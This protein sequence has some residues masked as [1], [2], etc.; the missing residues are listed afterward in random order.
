MSDS[1]YVDT[2]VLGSYFFPEVFSDETERLLQS[3]PRLVISNLTE[4]EFYSLAAKKLRTGKLDEAQVRHIIMKF[5]AFLAVDHFQ[6]ITLETADY[7]RSKA[8]LAELATNL[9]TLDALHI[10]AAERLGL[11]LMTSDKFQADGAE[12]F[13]L[14]VLRVGMRNA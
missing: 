14:E 6:R 10:A 7:V 5:E 12:F 3:I 2:G 11:P 9:R 1:A 8:Y 4:V 13:G